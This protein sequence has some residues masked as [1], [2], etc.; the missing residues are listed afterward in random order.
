MRTTA[1]RALVVGTLVLAWLQPPPAL[2]H[3]LSGEGW[4]YRSEGPC[5]YQWT[6][7][8][9][10]DGKLG[11]SARVDS[12]ERIPLPEGGQI[13]CRRPKTVPPSFMRAA[14]VLLKDEGFGRESACRFT[15]FRMNDRAQQSFMMAEVWNDTPC[16]PGSYRVAGDGAIMSNNEWHGGVIYTP[17][18]PRPGGAVATAS[19]PSPDPPPVLPLVG[20]DGELVRDSAGAVVLVRHDPTLADAPLAL[21]STDPVAVK[22]FAA[23]RG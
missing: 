15:Q 12:W 5:T 17:H 14:L 20:L 22:A 4:T 19:S 13:R 16:G 21:L 6:G 3:Q 7:M 8:S 2:A 9:H 1:I 23:A 11:G 10:G 18:H